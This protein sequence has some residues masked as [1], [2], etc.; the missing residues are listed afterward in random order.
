MSARPECLNTPAGLAHNA[1]DRSRETR[2][3]ENTIAGR[4]KSY[5]K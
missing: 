3:E 1:A 5:A 4:G 2:H